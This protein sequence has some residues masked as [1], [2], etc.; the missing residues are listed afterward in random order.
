M[1]T[2]SNGVSNGTHGTHHA[3]G[4]LQDKVAIVTGS[5]SGLGRAIAI[6]FA[7]QGAKVVCADLQP[8]ARVFVDAASV[9][10]THKV[11]NEMGG[12]SLFIK[13][14]VSDSNGVQRMVEKTVQEFG[15][16]DMY[17]H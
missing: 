7:R 8:Q 14:D 11:I 9:K 17:V 15:R 16:L 2:T 13:V 4:R 10:A 1:N 12:E 5:S 3:T 6:T